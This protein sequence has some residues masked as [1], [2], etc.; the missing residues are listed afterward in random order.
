MPKPQKK[1]RVR[2]VA[3]RDGPKKKTERK[4]RK[5]WEPTKCYD[6]PREHPGYNKGET[7][8][9]GKVPRCMKHVEEYDKA[10]KPWPSCPKCHVKDGFGVMVWNGS[11]KKTTIECDECGFKGKAIKYFD[12]LTISVIARPIEH[13]EV[14]RSDAE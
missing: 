12:E 1:A 2:I 4:P 13:V 3:P 7:R 8:K 10:H 6:C 9:R 11:A 5:K 14:D